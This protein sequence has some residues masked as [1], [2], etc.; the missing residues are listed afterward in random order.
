VKYCESKLFELE[1]KVTERSLKTIN[2]CTKSTN[3]NSIL[4]SSTA[5]Q[6]ELRCKDAGCSHL[7]CF[8][9]Q[10]T[11]PSP[12]PGTKSFYIPPPSNI[13]LLPRSVQSYQAYRSLQTSHECEEC[14]KGALYENYYEMV[15]YPEPGPCGNQ[16]FSSHLLSKQPQC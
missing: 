11:N 9:R 15:E 1:A 14:E 13:R 10:P 2:S 7:A 16:W 5:S 12:S 3:T 4:C 8:I 6:S